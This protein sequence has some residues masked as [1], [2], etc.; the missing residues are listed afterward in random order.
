[1]NEV[2]ADTEEGNRRLE[3]MRRDEVEKK[4]LKVFL[5]ETLGICEATNGTA[6]YSLLMSQVDPDIL[7]QLQF[8]FTPQQKAA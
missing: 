8:I 5:Q 1:M 6:K 4:T 2:T 7:K 3:L